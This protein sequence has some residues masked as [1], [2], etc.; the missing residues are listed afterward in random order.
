MKIITKETGY[1]IIP[2]NHEISKVRK[3]KNAT[4]YFKM[5]ESVI[6]KPIRDDNKLQDK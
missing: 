1:H 4:D 5:L 6:Y 2:S 3:N